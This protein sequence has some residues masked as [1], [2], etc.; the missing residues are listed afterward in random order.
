[1]IETLYKLEIGGNFLNLIQGIYEKRTANIIFNGEQLNALPSR[2]E[3]R[4]GRLCVC[5]CHFY[6]TFP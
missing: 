6:S 1:M 5:S 2:L 3:I 4:Q